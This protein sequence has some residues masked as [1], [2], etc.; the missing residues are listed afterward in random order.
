MAIALLNSEY[1]RIRPDSLLTDVIGAL[2][3]VAAN[4]GNADFGT[5]FKTA[6]EICRESLSNSPLNTPR[7]ILRSLIESIGADQYIGDQFFARI[8]S[9]IELNAGAPALAVQ[10]LTILQKES[11]K[12]FKVINNIDTSFTELTIEYD[13]LGEGEAEIGL[14]IPRIE[15][16]S[17]LQDLAKEF[18]EW[19]NALTPIVEVFDRNAPPLQ[20]RTCSTTDWM[21][22]LIATPA[23]LEGVSHCL[24]KVNEILREALEM[25]SL[26]EQIAR[27][28]SS[29][30]IAQLEEEN[31]N[32]I[33]TDLRKLAEEVVDERLKVHDQADK[34]DLKNRLAFS[35]QTIAFKVTAGTKVEVRLIPPSLE[36]VVDAEGTEG[37]PTA[38]SPEQEHLAELALTLDQEVSLLAFD[39]D[40]DALRAML[41]APVLEA[42]KSEQ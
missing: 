36:P 3:T 19:H 42:E 2:N 4:P 15:T 16:S 28:S 12:F 10:A 32:K 13:E 8:K 29:D 35:L 14:L 33:Q 11:Q 26:L 18:K 23:I 41:P 27:R 34:N 21:L 40:S 31:K 37:Q 22:Y 24:K 6:L 38:P 9:G 5:N 17:T 7:P 30:A 1:H 25:R 39:N 20:I